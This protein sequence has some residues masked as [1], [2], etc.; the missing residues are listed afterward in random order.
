VA[1]V[2]RVL[3]D[4]V[5]VHPADLHRS[6]TARVDERI[7]QLSSAGSCTVQLEL[8]LIGRQIMLWIGGIDIF[9]SSV[10][11]CLGAVRIRKFLAGNS[12]SKPDALD[13]A[14]VAHESQQRQV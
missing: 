9:E 12:A 4:H 5:D 14:H 11:I 13:V 3:L 8:P 6:V 2:A 7:V 10:W 1:V